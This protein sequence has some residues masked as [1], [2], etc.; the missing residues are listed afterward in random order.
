MGELVDEISVCSVDLDSVETGGDGVLCCLG[1]VLDVGLYFFLSQRCR[2]CGAGVVGGAWD[3]FNWDIA[4][5]DDFRFW[6]IF[7]FDD[8]FGMLASFAFRPE[9]GGYLPIPRQLYPRP[10]IARR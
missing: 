9:K 2:C 6:S 8:L 4:C 3:G 5:A 1:V 10:T 7:L